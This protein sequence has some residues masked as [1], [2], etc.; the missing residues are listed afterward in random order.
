[1]HFLTCASTGSDGGVNSGIEQCSHTYEEAGQN[2][3]ADLP[4]SG[5][6]TG[7][8]GSF[9]VGADCVQITAEL[10]LVQDQRCND[11]ECQQPNCADGDHVEDLG[12]NQYLL[13]PAADFSRSCGPGLSLDLGDDGTDTHGDHLRTQSSDKGGQTQL[14]DHDTVEQAKSHCNSQSNHNTNPQRQTPGIECVCADQSGAHH[15]STQRQVNAAGDN[16]EG[17]TEGHEADVVSRLQNVFRSVPGEEVVADDSKQ[18]VQDHECS[19]SKD[20]LHIDLK[21]LLFSILNFRHFLL[22]L[23][24]HA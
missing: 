12:T 2:I 11:K 14:C 19:G 8:T 3:C 7:Q 4:V 18:N 21:A 9:L 17:N 22:P 13:K 5:V 20:L 23:I 6:N 10:G 16:D 1:M 24:I 15:N